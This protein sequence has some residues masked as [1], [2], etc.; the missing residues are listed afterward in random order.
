MTQIF[1]SGPSTGGLHLRASDRSLGVNESPDLVNVELT[2]SG[3]ILKSNGYIRLNNTA[4]AGAPEI[5]GVYE[6][7]RANGDE[8][9]LVAA[10]GNLYELKDDGT[11]STLHTGM[12]V[13]AP[14]A[15]ETFN[16]LCIIVNGVDAPLKY[17]GSTVTGLANW[18]TIE[19]TGY[20][21]YAEVW[22]NRLWFT[23]NPQKPYRVYFSEPGNPEG[24]DALNGAGAVDVNINDGQLVTGIKT[25]F[26]SL[27][28]YK[29]RSIHQ[30][31]GDSAPG[32]GGGNEFRIKPIS[33]DLGCE[34][35]RTIVTVGNDQFFMGKDH[36]STIRTTD[37]F[38]D[39]LSQTISF[40]V[41][42]VF[43]E[44]N[45]NAIEGAFVVHHRPKNQIWFFY[46]DGSSAQNNKV[47]VFDYNLQ[48][49][50]RREGFMAS[51]GIAL[52]GKPTVG[53]YDGN[54]HK[55]DFGGNYDGGVIKAH[56]KTPWY[57]FNSFPVTKRVRSIDL[58]VVRLG[59]WFVN[60]HSSWDYQ[61]SSGAFTFNQSPG[62]RALWGEALWGF[63]VWSGESSGQIRKVSSIGFGKTLQL[64]FFNNFADQPFHI[65]GWDILYQS[66]GIR[67]LA[68]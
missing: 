35:P 16:D 66:R 64:R 19:S 26:D 10:G 14:V 47:L 3:G 49:W 60:M 45:Q 22:K 50:T 12:T 67:P 21:A 11:W 43:D 5:V 8:I 4:L 25:F 36:I 41:Q 65:L 1:S 23:G 44:M 18:T 58:S 6:Y 17:D 68:R 59:D 57:G 24:W 9:T 32:S 29:Q 56:Y 42:P 53:T 62:Q 34:A 2:Q 39:V 38:G 28:I 46:P 54:I 55:H 31:V 37:F 40:K 51:C 20:P 30:L 52:N 63:D 33:T 48:A 15:F 27:I 61:T 13:D 7:F